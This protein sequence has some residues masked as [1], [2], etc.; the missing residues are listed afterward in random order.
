MAQLGYNIL[1]TGLAAVAGLASA[2]LTDKMPRRPTLIIGTA[3]SAGWLAINA[4]LQTAIGR[5]NG[6]LSTSMA[7]GSL[8]AYFLFNVTFQFAYTPL[9][10]VLPA[11]ALE[12]TI[13]AKGLAA[14]SIF[15]GC[16]GFINQFAGPIALKNIGY[17][18]V[19]FFVGW[20][21]F[22]TVIWYFFLVEG[23]GRT[24]EELEWVY[25]QPNPV[26]ASLQ[27]DQVTVGQDG[28]VRR[29]VEE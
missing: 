7:S 22:E 20:D 15:G 14:G 2:L 13:R 16:M 3:A 5:S 17:K 4:G 21:T 1:Y 24:L 11:E 18:Y 25:Q 6:Q 26:K 28:V 19:W 29:Q 12:T 8:A 23:Q 27:F 9:Q 10:A